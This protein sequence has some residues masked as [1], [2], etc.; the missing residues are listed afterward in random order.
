[1]YLLLLILIVL[2]SFSLSKEFL[3]T[4]RLAMHAFMSHKSGL[5]A[6]HLGLVKAICVM[7]GWNSNIH[8]KTI[9]WFP[10][11]LSTAQ[12]WAQKEDL[13][14]WPPVIIIHNTS[15]LNND[16]NGQGPTSLEALGQF[17]RG[18]LLLCN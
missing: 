8:A 15:I 12:T 1:M 10:E 6:Q 13:I 11:P 7:L 3:D 4:Q 17:L 5:R 9:R 2:R 14:I 18:I 16:S